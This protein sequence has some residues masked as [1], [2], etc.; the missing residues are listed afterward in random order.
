MV[1]SAILS[2]KESVICTRSLQ[3]EKD[4][5]NI[6]SFR[7]FIEKIFFW[8]EVKPYV[9]HP[10]HLRAASRRGGDLLDIL[11]GGTKENYDKKLHL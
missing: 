2:E 6:D 4:R 10:N 5:Y 1:C 3:F 7:G 8:I 9:Q 11:V